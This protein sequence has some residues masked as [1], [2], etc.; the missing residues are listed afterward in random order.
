MQ[1][2]VSKKL[3]I[4]I[5]ILI[6]CTTFFI[7]PITGL[8]ID[9]NYP[10]T[11]EY[12]DTEG[13]ILFAPER[14]TKTY[15]M[16][17]EEDIVYSWDSNYNPGFS[18]Y[19]LSNGDL[20]RT[21]Y[22]GSHPIFFAGG[23]A[24]GFQE[25]TPDG[26][27][28]WEFEYKDTTHLSHHD[29]E[30][31]P[32]GNVLVI[33]WEYKSPTE[34]EKAGR[35]PENIPLDGLWPDHIIEVKKTGQTSGDVVWEWHAWDHL[36]QDYNPSK[37]NY[38]VVKDHPELIDINYGIIEADWL[39]SNSIDYNQD[40]DQI[41]ISVR[42][43]NE[44]WV[45]DHST[46]TQEAAG[47]TG[48]NS[49]K[50]GD[51]LYRWGNP[52]AYRAGTIND[53][54]FFGQHDAQWIKNGYPGEGNILVFNNGIDRPD[55]DYSS[56][57]E[58]EPLVDG[59]GNYYL[60]PGEAYDPDEP[61]WIYKSENP[62]DFFSASR[63]GAQRLIDGNTIICNSEEGYFFEVTSEGE[64]VW[65]YLNPYP[66]LSNNIVFKICKYPIDYPGIQELF[67]PPDTPS[68]PSGPA[69]GMVEVGY[70]YS[71]YTVDPNENQVFY[72]FDW[73]DGT[74]SGWLGPYDSGDTCTAEKVWYEN[75]SYKVKVKAKDVYE[76]ESDWSNPLNVIIGNVAP[77]A[78]IIHGPTNGRIEIQ[79]DYSFKSIDQNNDDIRYIITWGD[80]NSITTDYYS[81]ETEITLSHSWGKTGK[82]KIT[83][84][85]EDSNGL[86]GPERKLDITI[87]K[88][89]GI[90]TQFLNFLE[91]Y[92]IIYQLL[93][94][95]F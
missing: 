89:K 21:C 39:H 16:N 92:P 90:N 7:S 87:S 12:I 36:I 57:D 62:K 30:P 49:G 17:Y 75:G 55:A 22:L 33:A 74:D 59:N 64:V 48:G 42:N 77:D 83:A 95:L 72:L 60:E 45:I 73:D 61:T 31:L 54:M 20:L 15:L 70:S 14:S 68:T 52:K 44:I 63:S 53:Q 27:I 76:L 19:L 85:A 1:L 93:Q 50:G 28:A 13:Y 41:V 67:Q 29:I 78:P 2:I 3:L 10:K 11:K 80:E 94:K 51:I 47:H 9:N 88:N 25:I 23:M 56:V 84:K 65:D 35:N 43:F 79:Y 81:S 18:A 26:E 8:S 71:S 69:I 91:N 46:T 34:V 37:D 66:D 4:F 86:I 5:Y 82:Y 40:F 24:G 38:G 32:N 6:F 58:I